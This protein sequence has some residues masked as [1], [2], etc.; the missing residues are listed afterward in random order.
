MSIHR[1]SDDDA[2]VSLGFQGKQFVIDPPP[3]ERHDGA[4]DLV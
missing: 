3:I 1:T 2:P 4:L